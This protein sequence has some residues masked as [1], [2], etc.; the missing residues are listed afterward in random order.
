MKH[1]THHLR[2]ENG[3]GGFSSFRNKYRPSPFPGRLKIRPIVQEERIQKYP[4]P[5]RC[6]SLLCRIHLRADTVDTQWADRFARADAIIEFIYHVLLTP[7]TNL[8]K[9]I[10]RPLTGNI[11]AHFIKI[12]IYTGNTIYNICLESFYHLKLKSIFDI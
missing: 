3:K 9:Y 6:P 7:P 12:N 1:A 4:V 8:T 2:V 5:S 11:F 10:L